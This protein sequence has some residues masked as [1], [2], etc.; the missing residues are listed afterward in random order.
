MAAS[1]VLGVYLSFVTPTI[2]RSAINGRADT[3]NANTNTPGLL[4]GIR[5]RTSSCLPLSVIKKWRQ[6]WWQLPD[7]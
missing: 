5:D 2:A 1:R 6:P 7:D 3:D 4:P